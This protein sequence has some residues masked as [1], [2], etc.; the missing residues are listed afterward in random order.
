MKIFH[1][2]FEMSSRFEIAKRNKVT[3][4]LTS[5][6]IEF[7]KA[8]RVF[9]RALGKDEQLIHEAYNG[10]EQKLR[11]KFQKRSSDR[12]CSYGFGIFLGGLGGTAIGAGLAGIINASLLYGLDNKL[13]YGLIVAGGT[14]GAAGLT[15]FFLGDTKKIDASVNDR[16]IE[17]QRKRRS[18]L[19]NG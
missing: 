16:L 4:E 11:D 9:S 17:F 15:R 2:A 10:E 18:F 3:Q 5:Y 1:G 8:A 14:S 13:F 7:N 6:E 12:R 19:Q